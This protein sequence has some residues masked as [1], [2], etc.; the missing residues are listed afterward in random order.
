MKTNRIQWSTI[1]SVFFLLLM[2]FLCCFCICSDIQAYWYKYPYIPS[3]GAFLWKTIV[4]DTVPL[5]IF[6][7]SIICFKRGRKCLVVLC[8]LLFLPVYAFLWL[9]STAE[10]LY[11]PTVCSYTTEAKNLG[12]Y[13]TRVAQKLSYEPSAFFPDSIPDDAENVSYLYYYEYASCT[14][15]YIAVAWDH[16]ESEYRQMTAKLSAAAEGKQLDNETFY[17]FSNPNYT[18][19]VIVD[20]S[21]K[22]I[23][24]VIVTEKTFLPDGKTPKNTDSVFPS[25]KSLIQ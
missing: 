8:F 24:Y 4:N 7:V 13:D 10:I 3:L 11:V 1:L 18:D 6:I 22:R 15:I 9:R 19:V 21:Q 25:P 5:A 16:S 23:Y 12:N 17:S 20:H 2:G 14:K